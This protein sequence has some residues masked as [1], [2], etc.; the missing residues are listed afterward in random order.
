M[1]A[2]T[3]STP[4]VRFAPFAAVVLTGCFAHPPVSQLPSAEAALDRLRATGSCGA[5]VQAEAKVDEF[6]KQGR[7]R[8][9]LLMFAQAPA[10][11][12]MDVV[13]PFGV[14]LATLT[15]DGSRFALADLRD[16]RFYVGPASACNIA[17]FTTVAV[18]GYVMVDLL[19][20]QAPVLKRVGTPT[21]AWSGSGYYVLRIGSTRDAKE[22][23][24]L[25]PHPDDFGKPW[26]EQRMRLLDVKVEQ[27]GGVV[28]HA[29]LADHRGTT[30]APARVDPDGVE[31]PLPPSGPACDAEIPRS[32]HVEVPGERADVLFR[33]DKVQWNPPLPE[34]T[35]VQPPTDAMPTIPVT[36][37]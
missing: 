4:R 36:C 1:Q 2:R 30:T 24:H 6:A 14:T 21:I 35:F 37:D 28:Y 16:R 3:F 5:G 8:L 29:E 11:M 9:D 23:I 26:G 27:Y 10:R 19:R 31:P 25:V 7:V 22:E 13:S 17:R 20:G 33:Y 32:I 18:P 34:G 12:R 15:S